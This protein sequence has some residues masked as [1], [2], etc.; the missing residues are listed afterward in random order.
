MLQ[1]KS[2]TT[3]R[4]NGWGDLVYLFF[5][6]IVSIFT[7]REIFFQIS[8]WL[9]E[10]NIKHPPLMPTM[11]EWTKV[12]GGFGGGQDGVEMYALYILMF[13]NIALVFFVTQLSRPLLLT[14]TSKRTLI[15]LTVTS[16]IFYLSN[17]GINFPMTGSMAIKYAQIEP[18]STLSTIKLVVLIC[19][20]TG[21]FVF[22]ANKL[23]VTT[24]NIIVFLILLPSCFIAVGP[25]SD[26]YVFVFF[27]A[28]QLLHNVP[29]TDIYFQY[30]IFLSGLALLWLKLDFSMGSF[31]AVGQFSLVITI[32]A[33]Y[34][35]AHNLFSRRTLAFFLFFF[36]VLLRLYAGPGESVSE[37][38]GTPLR[39]DLWIILYALI[40]FLGAYHWSVGFTCGLFILFHRNFG[41]IYA[42]AY[43]QS[44]VI[45]FI[46]A[47][48]DRPPGTTLRQT[49]ESY[50]RKIGWSILWAFLF[51]VLT[52]L[53]FGTTTPS[54]YY[55]SIGFG[56]LKIQ[57]NSIYW[58]FPIILS[59]AA[60]LLLT[61]RRQLST[62]YFSLGIFLI[63]CSIGNSVYFFGRS[64]EWNLLTISISLLFAFF[65]FLDLLDRRISPVTS[66]IRMGYLLLF[67]RHLVLVITMAF[68]LLITW[69]YVPTINFKLNKQLTTIQGG[70]IHRPNQFP[71]EIF[72]ARQIIKEVEPLMIEG[73][74]IEFFELDGSLEFYLYF[75]RE[76]PSS[77]FF[78]PSET[79]LF[80]ST[81]RNYVYQQLA[82]EN[83][84]LLSQKFVQVFPQLSSTLSSDESVFSSNVTCPRPWRSIDIAIPYPG[85]HEDL[86][87]HQYEQY[88]HN[89]PDLV[90][91]Y[92]TSSKDLTIAKWGQ[93]HYLNHGIEEGRGIIDMATCWIPI[94]ANYILFGPVTASKV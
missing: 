3:N 70:H 19:F 59:S 11:E 80:K 15:F 74:E 65:L 49:F 42:A 7:L 13:L 18:L 50:S 12:G 82:R 71:D 17:V 1:T 40:Y 81:F 10:Q 53:Y 55:R 64:H 29:I 28:L 79:W 46:V 22:I 8:P 84:I 31:Q 88:V 54:E 34:W 92:S 6:S 63:T 85:G 44:L 2:L 66:P 45:F 61:L 9:W 30:D 5:I 67:D 76:Q 51:F 43:M 16:C 52:F 36:L 89:H 37:L 73:R 23:P 77:A 91:A 87:A 56:F 72:K 21:I 83:Y 38:Q 48:V 35:F 47:V 41:L 24:S 93:N 39:L 86:T 14:I 90:A 20:L 75:L 33:C 57:D 62:R 25:V 94:G 32:F 4:E 26:N 69:M 27:P 68:F 58:F 60:M 78:R